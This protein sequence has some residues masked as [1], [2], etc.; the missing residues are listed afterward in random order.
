MIQTGANISTSKINWNIIN[1][2]R[3]L[4]AIYVVINHSRSALFTDAMRYA[5]HVHPKADWSYWEWFNILMMQH[6]DLGSEFVILFFVL[7]G[8]SIAH[9]LNKNTDTKAF[10][11]RRAIRLYPP[12][13]L[14]IVWALV[15]FLIIKEDA[16]SIF[17]R[18][19]EGYKPLYIEFYKFENI[20]T[21]LY[22]LLYIP[23]DNYLTPQYW[24]LP[25]EVL[26]YLIAPWAV[27]KLRIYGLL[28]VGIYIFA[29]WWRGYV[30][31]DDQKDPI[32]PQ[33]IIDYN[34][35][36][37]VG[38]VFYTYRDYF[39]SKFRIK[40]I[41]SLALLAV[42]FELLV[43]IKSYLF[44]QDS[45][46][47]TGIGMIL[48]SFVILFS[49]LKYDIRIK[50]LENIGVFSYTLYV[51]HVA[52]LFLV[53]LVFYKLGLNFYNIYLIYGWYFGI[54]AS[55]LLAATLYYVAEYPAIRQ[56]D[57]MR[58]KTYRTA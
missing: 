9:S 4:A 51:T 6:T 33:Y 38:V 31:F 47:I 20:K 1:W 49:G 56:L 32:I 26:F 55:L 52:S 29:W 27:K 10:F 46:R 45:N 17:Y 19:T 12:Y 21:L 43:I 44:H 34:V 25:F 39:I 58:E 37:F 5:A 35:Y 28:T 7:S 30:Y 57:R 8:F 2:M 18:Q 3:G 36:F 54:A 40:P 13:V 53:K 16:A 50:P 48:F 22:N 42:I 24:S 11:I 41:Y 15:V 14:G 23:K